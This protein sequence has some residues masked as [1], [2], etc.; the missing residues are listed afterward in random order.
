MISRV[1]IKLNDHII[2]VEGRMTYN[3]HS[4]DITDVQV[5]KSN[6]T[7]SFKIP[8]TEEV[9]RIFNGLGI[10]GDIS[11]SAY[12]AHDVSVLEEGVEAYKGTLVILKSDAGH[13]HCSVIA[14]TRDFFS[15]IQDVTFADLDIED[16]VH[17]KSVNQVRSGLTASNNNPLAYFLANFGGNPNFIR[18]ENLY[19]N[20]DYLSPAIS[21]QYLLDKAFDYAG[22]TYE[23]PEDVEDKINPQSSLNEI[24]RVV[25][26]YPPYL[27]AGADGE[28]VARGRKMNSTGVV[29]SNDEF[30]NYKG[31]NQ[32]TTT[33]Q[34]FS[35]QENWKFVCNEAGEYILDF[36]FFRASAFSTA[37]KGVVICRVYRNG[38]EIGNFTFDEDAD[39]HTNVYR[40]S[41]TLNAGDV[42]DFSLFADNLGGI[43]RT[44][45]IYD[46]QFNILSADVDAESR[47]DI[48]G[49]S[50]TTFI[51]EFCYRFGLMPTQP[52]KNKIK[53]I[54]IKELVNINNAI[55]WSD[56]FNRR[57]EESYDN[58]F[59]VN[60]YLKHRY[61]DEVVN[62]WDAVYVSD[63]KNLKTTNDL[64]SSSF[65]APNGTSW[66]NTGVEVIPT[67][68]YP[69]Y[70]ISSGDRAKT[71]NRYMFTST[72]K[73]RVAFRLGSG[74]LP[75]FSYAPDG[76]IVNVANYN[77]YFDGNEYWKPLELFMSNPRK[78]NIELYLNLMD[79][80]SLDLS[81]PYYFRQENAYF[82]IK[83][84]KYTRGSIATAECIRIDYKVE[85]MDGIDF[86]I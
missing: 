35:T 55:D 28:I 4:A 39:E 44:Y 73:D 59:G 47:E 61:S 72:Y 49:L 56:K 6:Y 67:F 36:P 21:V 29:L 2:P 40:T 9:K 77:A 60:N 48:F 69:I 16:V 80:R 50:L 65:Y 38:S 79:I 20:I 13:Y 23:I 74:T 12:K 63:N 10:V 76:V 41:V 57:I 5:S 62:K 58:G 86:D 31:F 52:E 42:I 30:N 24:E 84:L 3:F 11:T 19:L 68:L 1:E 22:F 70:E 53:F 18:D 7:S 71:N 15:E 78:M 83:S 14:G 54:Q 85:L 37:G 17:P 75:G 34:Y 45:A 81:K 82:I 43:G 26:P 33:H 64:I 27:E 46:I 8:R 25:F 51:K 66:L 32:M